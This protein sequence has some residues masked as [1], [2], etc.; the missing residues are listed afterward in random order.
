M[1][2]AEKLPACSEASWAAILSFMGSVLLTVWAAMKLEVRSRSNWWS[3]KMNTWLSISRRKNTS[4]ESLWNAENSLRK[5]PSKSRQVM[6]SKIH[7]F[8]SKDM[9]RII[10]SETTDLVKWE[11]A[12]EIPRW[13]E[14]WSR[15]GLLDCKWEFQSGTWK[16]Q[17][18]GR[19]RHFDPGRDWEPHPFHQ[20]FERDG[21][22]WTWLTGRKHSECVFDRT[23]RPSWSRV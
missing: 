8:E 13:N 12:L 6:G 21:S 16:S 14:I 5:R 4:K 15:D 11:N 3:L 2:E 19:Y 18:Q 17:R 1:I 10:S 20:L 23:L 22:V 9:N 7:F